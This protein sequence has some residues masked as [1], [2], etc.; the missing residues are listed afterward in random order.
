MKKQSFVLTLNL[1]HADSFDTHRSYVTQ[2]YFETNLQ[3]IIK[4]KILLTA[5]VILTKKKDLTKV[6]CSV[7]LNRKFSLILVCIL[8]IFL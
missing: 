3:F 5:I 4:L 2:Y 6:F 1:L 7:A 8:Q